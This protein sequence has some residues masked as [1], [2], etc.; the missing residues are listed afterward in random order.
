MRQG[1]AASAIQRAFRAHRLRDE[2]RH[3]RHRA[4]WSNTPTSFHSYFD[5]DVFGHRGYVRAFARRRPL[6]FRQR[7]I[8]NDADAIP[9]MEYEA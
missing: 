4:R 6:S 8:M 2:M 9:L 5:N 3:R 1:C 7:Y